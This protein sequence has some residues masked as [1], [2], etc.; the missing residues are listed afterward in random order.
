MKDLDIFL[1]VRVVYLPNLSPLMS[2]SIEPLKQYLCGGGARD[3]IMRSQRLYHEEPEII[4]MRS[5]R[6]YHEEPEI[7]SC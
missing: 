6:L 4:S 1:S 3:H 5:Q 7:I 2:M